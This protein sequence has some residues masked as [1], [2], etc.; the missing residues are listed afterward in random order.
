MEIL[1]KNSYR[2]LG[3]SAPILVRTV[4]LMLAVCCMWFVPAAQ[5]QAF[6]AAGD[7]SFTSKGVFKITLTPALGGA[8]FVIKVAGPTCV[9]R[10]DPHAQGLPASTL[11]SPLGDG[12]LCGPPTAATSDI[13][14]GMP[15]PAG[16]NSGG[17]A[18]EVHTE[19][20]DM[21]LT[22][23]AGWSI[24]IGPSTTGPCPLVR[25]LGEVEARGGSGFPADSFFYLSVEVFVPPAF[26]GPMYLYNQVPLTVEAMGITSFP[27]VSAD[28]MHSF[29]IS[30]NVRLYDCTTGC[31]I[32]T[33]SQGT[34]KVGG[35][36]P[37]P[38]TLP[39]PLRRLMVV[40]PVSFSV[41]VGAEGLRV[42]DPCVPPGHPEP[43]DV[44]ALGMAGLALTPPSWGYA[45]EGELFQSSGAFLGMPSDLTNVDRIS[46]ALGIGPAPAGPPY[47]G[48]FNPNTAAPIPMPAPP[49]GIGTFGLAPGDN[50]NSLSFGQDCGDTLL[51]SVEPTAVGLVGTAVNFQS[52][53]SPTAPPLTSGLRVPSNGG[54]D[55]GAEAAGD[56][57]VSSSFS[58]FGGGAFGFGV[59]PA[60]SGG[61]ILLIDEVYLGLQ[62]P[63]VRHSIGSAGGGPGSPPEDDLDA[64][65]AADA[66][67][68]DAVDNTTSAPPSDGIIDAGNFVFFTLTA[69]SPSLAPPLTPNDV[70]VST[71]PTP[72]FAFAVYANGVANIGLAPT[73]VIDAL[74]VS[75]APFGL[76]DGILTPIN[77]RALFSLAAG[78]PSLAGSPA[79]PNMPVGPLSPGDVFHTD[80]TG[81]VAGGGTGVTLYA[82]AASLGL[83]ASDDLDALDID[84]GFPCEGGDDPDQDG[85][86]FPC[87]ICPDVYN[88]VNAYGEQDNADGDS[89][90][91][92]CDP[93]PYAYNTYDCP[94]GACY[95]EFGCTP[96]TEFDCYLEEGTYWVEEPCESD[97]P[98]DLNG[99]DVVDINDIFEILGL[100]GPCPDPCPPY[101]IGDPTE[102]CTVN[103]DDLFTILGM[104]G[105]CE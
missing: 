54:G 82:S 39:P 38:P 71:A 75:D 52:T 20:V 26:G 30:G 94:T 104:W 72:G 97:C 50:M 37:A 10:S 2:S 12:S 87:D 4:S 81:P 67:V 34:H 86:G 80:F 79:F 15:F 83:L 53:L 101:C 96:M 60:L 14:I 51:F 6:P 89:D 61:N 28:Y 8:T 62:A 74:A 25:S 105:P 16:Y 35:G 93:C 92:A 1:C 19:I 70:L 78:S 29:S 42:P 76:P 49:G 31:L 73:D 88:P 84:W 48:P 77:D 13:M 55:P 91:D 40:P 90:G 18:D 95:N 22:N 32:G 69:A 102:D 59:M 5:A 63:A 46:S 23:V 44:F 17:G 64:L 24:A 41:D 100:W 43:N 3:A 68:V 45:T 85:V 11:S 56:I 99:D 66:I 36:T 9:V 47:M 58:F 57:F 27:P 65:E 103:I 7:D 98:G 33:L 21:L